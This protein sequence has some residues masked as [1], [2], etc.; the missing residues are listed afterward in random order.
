MGCFFYATY[1]Y[2]HGTISTI[3]KRFKIPSMHSGIIGAGHDITQIFSS[4]LTCYYTAKGHKP[5]W[6]GRGLML[7]SCYCFLSG[8]PHFIFGPGDDSLALTK[9]YIDSFGNDSLVSTLEIFE[10]QKQ[11]RICS[12]NS[13]SSLVIT[14]CKQE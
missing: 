13:E 6:I 11:S 10:R 2:Y 14:E 3:E 8:L 4:V 9:E 12:A 1:T 5:R 7:I